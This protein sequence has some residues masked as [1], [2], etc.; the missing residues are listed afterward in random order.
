MIIRLGSNRQ[1]VPGADFLTGFF[2][3]EQTVSENVSY[4]NMKPKDTA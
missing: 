1:V 2:S 4:N 3:I